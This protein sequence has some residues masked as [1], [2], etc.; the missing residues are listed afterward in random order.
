MSDASTCP[1]CNGI[2]QK[3]KRVTYRPNRTISSIV[4]DVKAQCEACRGTGS[5]NREGA[6]PCS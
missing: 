6:K 2:G 4:Y 5:V 3:I 1:R